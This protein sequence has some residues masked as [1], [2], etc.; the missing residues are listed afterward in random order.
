M[1][2]KGSAVRTQMPSA[3]ST[4]GNPGRYDSLPAPFDTPH[5]VGNG[6]IPLKVMENL[7]AKPTKKVSAAFAPPPEAGT[8]QNRS[9]RYG[10]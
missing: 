4:K 8:R 5:D 6:G 2:V 10:K 9:K 1:A 7:G 3:R